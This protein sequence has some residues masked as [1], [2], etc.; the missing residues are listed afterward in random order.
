[1]SSGRF[2]GMAVM[3]LS[4]G[5]AASAQ[6]TQ[7]VS[8]GSS[9]SPST[10]YPDSTGQE[11]TDGVLGLDF[12]AYNS[13]PE[14]S[15]WTGWD[16]VSPDITFEFGAPTTFSRI[17]I[18]TNRH[19]GAGNGLVQSITVSGN[20]FNFAAT[21]L[22]NDTRGWLVLDGTFATNGAGS[23][24]LAFGPHY[25]QWFFLDE[26]RFT[27]VP[28]PADTAAIFGVVLIGVTMAVRRR[29]VRLPATTAP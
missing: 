13:P 23:L 20:T 8:Y 2:I 11:L 22:P 16:N 26:V 19:V 15:V 3:M 4:L 21:D 25:S 10:Y 18:G 14:A 24:T 5:V 27:A 6:F 28:E 9:A 29:G 17:E 12:T 1:M 7:P